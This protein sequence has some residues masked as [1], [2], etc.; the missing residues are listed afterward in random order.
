VGFIV[1]KNVGKCR[2]DI[3]KLKNVTALGVTGT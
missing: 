2:E 3:K 1:H